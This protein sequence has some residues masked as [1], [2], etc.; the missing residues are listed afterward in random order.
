MD[1]TNTEWALEV[2]EKCDK[3]DRL[4]VTYFD[5]KTPLCARHATIFMTVP[6]DADDAARTE[7]T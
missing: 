6:R 3:C 5:G 1:D 7:A 4:A 2:R